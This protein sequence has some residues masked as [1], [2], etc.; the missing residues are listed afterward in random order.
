MSSAAF[1]AKVYSP[2]SLRVQ[3]QVKFAPTAPVGTVALAGVG[4]VQ[5]A[6]P[7]LMPPA[8]MSLG[9]TFGTGTA[10]APL[11]RTFIV[12]VTVPPWVTKLLLTFM[13]VSSTG[14]PG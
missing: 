5:L 2:R 10:P 11:V 9:D 6:V 12:T 1:P 7:P 13:A 8:L 4:P 14:G 3:V